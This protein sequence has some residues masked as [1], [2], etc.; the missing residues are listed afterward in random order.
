MTTNAL[1][2]EVGQEV[3]ITANVTDDTDALVTPSGIL[4]YLE[5]PD[6]TG[7][8]SATAD[9]NPSTG[10]YKKYYTLTQRGTYGI[11][12]RSTNP[13]AVSSVH[14]TTDWSAA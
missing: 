3:V 14:V 2:V 7:P 6:G 10:V 1:T 8:T 9:A 4:F 13:T 12:V 5:A 11:T